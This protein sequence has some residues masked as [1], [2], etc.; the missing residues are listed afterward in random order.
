MMDRVRGIGHHS[1]HC[2]LTAEEVLNWTKSTGFQDNAVL[3]LAGRFSRILPTVALASVQ[4][5]NTA[6]DIHSQTRSTLDHPVVI[7]AVVHLPSQYHLYK[8]TSPQHGNSREDAV[9][10]AVLSPSGN[11][12]RW[13][14]RFLHRQIPRRSAG[15]RPHTATTEVPCDWAQGQSLV[16]AGGDNCPEG[17]QSVCST[18]QEPRF[19]CAKDLALD[20]WE[21]GKTVWLRV[22]SMRGSMNHWVRQGARLH[23]AQ[24]PCPAGA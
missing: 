10:I 13:K 21:D 19:Y 9:T 22:L 16:W 5:T 23:C 3:T 1:G 4:N 20:R 12:Q 15:L 18:T 14:G 11:A 6:T 7:F 24:S 2:M 17:D 8:T